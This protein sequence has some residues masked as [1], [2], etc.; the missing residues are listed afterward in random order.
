MFVRTDKSLGLLPHY[1][2]SSGRSRDKR[3]DVKEKEQPKTTTAKSDNCGP[4]AGTGGA[5]SILKIKVGEQRGLPVPIRCANISE[6]SVPTAAHSVVY[7]QKI[8]SLN[9]LIVCRRQEKSPRECGASE[10]ADILLRRDHRRH[11]IIRSE[12]TSATAC[13][14]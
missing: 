3:I 5:A 4:R 14:T 8:F 12:C 6:N 7:L 9:L 13:N 1:E 10:R 2:R 11:T